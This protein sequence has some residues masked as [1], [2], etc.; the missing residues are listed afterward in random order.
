LLAS[1]SKRYRKCDE[2]LCTLHVVGLVS[3]G[4]TILCSDGTGNTILSSFYVFFY[5]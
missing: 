1:G 5:F 2:S 3:P 4:Q